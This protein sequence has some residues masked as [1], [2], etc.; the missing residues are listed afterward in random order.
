MHCEGIY[1]FSGYL[2]SI[3]YLIEIVLKD[4]VLVFHHIQ[5]PG[6]AQDKGYLVLTGCN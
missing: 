3:S 5:R 2:N 6:I 1:S 4:E